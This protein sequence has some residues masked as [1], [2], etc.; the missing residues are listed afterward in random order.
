MHELS[1]ACR[2]PKGKVTGPVD[3]PR[4]LLHALGKAVSE[5]QTAVWSSSLADQ[6]LLQDAPLAHAIPHD[7]APG[8]SLVSALANGE[9][10]SD[11][12][13]S[14][15]GYPSFEVQ[16]LIPPGQSGELSFAFFEPT[17]RAEPRFPTQPSADTIAPVVSVPECSE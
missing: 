9:R 13:R 2:S 3:S 15:P 12:K 8:T 5:R 4:K 7:P 11:I 14:E 1:V 16:V 6:Q 17:S 10:A